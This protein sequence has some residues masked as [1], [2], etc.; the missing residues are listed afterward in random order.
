MI[1][2]VLKISGV[3][4]SMAILYY[5]N[6]SCTIEGSD[7]R[8]VAIRYSGAIEIDDQT[9]SNFMLNASNNKIIITQIE[10]SDALNNLFNYVGELK[11]LRVVV[12]DK[13]IEPVSTTIKKVMDYSELLTTNAEDMTT[14]SE[15]LSA[16]HRH[17]KQI[18]KTVLKNPIM[19]DRT[20]SRDGRPLYFKDGTEYNG[21]YHIHLPD[22]VYM[23]GGKHT[24]QSETLYIRKK[25]NG[26]YKIITFLE[27]YKAVSS[28]IGKPLVKRKRPKLKSYHISRDE[29]RKKAG[30]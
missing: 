22:I 11:I 20:T 19:E 7:I 18:S 30:Y 27:Y 14:I 3:R 5:G 1:V 21:S 12:V 9:N 10:A 15:N 8:S 16:A 25:I 24:N 2:V 4:D 28:K 13:N 29:N 26:E 23:T 17:G 6:G